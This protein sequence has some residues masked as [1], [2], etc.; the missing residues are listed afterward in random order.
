MLQSRG[1]RLAAGATVFAASAFLGFKYRV[2]SAPAPAD[3]TLP[4]GQLEIGNYPAMSPARQSAIQ[5]EGHRS[6]DLR[7]DLK[8]PLNVDG[9]QCPLLLAVYRNNTLK[10]EKGLWPHP[11]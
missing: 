11:S 1:V 4:T 8:V 9:G 2:A 10:H 7:V 5:R 3:E 6:R